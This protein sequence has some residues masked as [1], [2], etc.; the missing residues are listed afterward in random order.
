MRRGA[1]F[2]QPRQAYLM[3]SN[4]TKAKI[5]NIIINPHG[6]RLFG[7]LELISGWWWMVNGVEKIFFVDYSIFRREKDMILW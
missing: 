5:Q 6:F 3:N 7:E 1:Q 2:E 4:E